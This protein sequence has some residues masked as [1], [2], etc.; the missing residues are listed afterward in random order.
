[1]T[2]LVFPLLYPNTRPLYYPARAG[3]PNYKEGVITHSPGRPET[4]ASPTWA[5]A[6]VTRTFH[7]LLTVYL[8]LRQTLPDSANL[9]PRLYSSTMDPSYKSHICR[10]IQPLNAHLSSLRKSVHPNVS[11]S[12]AQ[13]NLIITYIS[14][15]HTY[16]HYHK[17]ALSH[18]H[19]HVLLLQENA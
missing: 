10:T 8:R 18:N 6:A 12:Q 3:I 19:K 1:M 2:P 9:P 16:E 15:I 4:P 11:V 14:K 7:T 17:A 5:S 13:I